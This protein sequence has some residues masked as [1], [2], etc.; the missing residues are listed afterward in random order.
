MLLLLF[1]ASGD[2]K[3]R[4]GIQSRL[5]TLSTSTAGASVD[6]ADAALEPSDSADVSED[7]AANTEDSDI[8]EH[9]LPTAGMPQ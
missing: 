2:R 4:P 1:A 7:D 8:A 6:D 5:S 3:S 9:T